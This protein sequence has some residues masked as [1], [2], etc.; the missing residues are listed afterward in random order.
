MWKVILYRS[1][2]HEVPSAI[3]FTFVFKM[4]IAT[5]HA[6]GSGWKELERIPINSN[7]GGKN[8]NH[9]LLQAEYTDEVHTADMPD[10]YR[11]TPC[12][13][14]TPCRENERKNR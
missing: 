6:V 1:S 5:L 9:E 7:R 13:L 12:R 10:Y 4:Q 11:N 14:C 8:S 3:Q 2:T